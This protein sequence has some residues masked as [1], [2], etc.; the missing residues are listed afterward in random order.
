MTIADRLFLAHPAS[1]SETY[2]QHLAAASDFGGR[3]ILAGIACLIHGL[4][5][6]CFSHTA[7][8]Q[9]RALHREIESRRA[10]R[11][12]VDLGGGVASQG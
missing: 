2:G 12:A 3:L 11:P 10:P 1:V 8:D 6:C 9:I 4:L 7:S 5:P